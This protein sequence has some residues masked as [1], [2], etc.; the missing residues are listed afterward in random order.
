MLEA[1]F[2]HLHID[3][4]E[5]VEIS[6]WFLCH[7][8]E[9]KNFKNKFFGTKILYELLRIL[10]A[11]SNPSMIVNYSIWFIV[12]LVKDI[13]MD[14]VNDTNKYCLPS[15]S[16]TKD[17]PEEIFIKILKTFNSY[18]YVNEIEIMSN[19]VWGVYN[20][21]NV[22]DAFLNVIMASGITV[23]IM[24]INLKRYQS[25]VCPVVRLL[26]NLCAGK[27]SIVEV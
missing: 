23:K 6:M 13:S 11:N 2:K 3:H 4:I 26:G 7:L 10:E 24:S 22:D 9:L 15:N 21:S 12:Q 8:A 27:N 20:V 18:L 16:D 25:L 19:C 5:I 1:Y 14:D 17:T